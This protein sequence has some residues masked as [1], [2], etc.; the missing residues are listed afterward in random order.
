MMLQLWKKLMLD[1]Q[2]KLEPRLLTLQLILSFKMI[3][4]L[5]L[6]RH[7]SGVEMFTITLEDS[8]NFSSL[9]MLSLLSFHS[10]PHQSWKIHH[11]SQFNFFG[12]IWSWTPLLPLLSQLSCQLMSFC[13]DHH[14]E[15]ESISFQ[16]RWSST[17]LV[18]Q[19]SKHLFFSSSY[20][21]DLRS[22][23]K[24]KICLIH[25]LTL[26]MANISWVVC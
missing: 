6:W 15:R 11:S 25:I 21:L 18:N 17:L 5:Q 9:S 4:L 3:T 20:S 8:C 2:W 16:E 22:S 12:S 19:F 24:I 13:T 1:L 7:A 10:L 26:K 14:I 23:R